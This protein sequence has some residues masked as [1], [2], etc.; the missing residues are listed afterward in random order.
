MP[1]T[2]TWPA[3]GPGPARRA[4]GPCPARLLPMCLEE[5]RPCPVPVTESCWC[6]TVRPPRCGGAG[7]PRGLAVA[8][9]RTRPL[10]PDPH[11]FCRTPT[12]GL[13]SAS[14]TQ[15]PTGCR[16]EPG[17]LNHLWTAPS[18]LGPTLG[19]PVPAPVWGLP[20]ALPR[21]LGPHVHL[22]PLSTQCLRRRTLHFRKPLPVGLR[23]TGQA[24]QGFLRPTL[25]AAP[26]GS[27]SPR[28]Y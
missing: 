16:Q 28:K 21:A 6:T 24:W 27:A 7:R 3:V 11:A 18:D 26:P 10:L 1:A 2:Q 22:R 5:G 8:S 25:R 15:C 14:L 12:S 23:S 9:A 19:H 20:T 4:L 13:G 17:T